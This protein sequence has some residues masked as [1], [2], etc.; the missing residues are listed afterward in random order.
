MTT[1]VTS[2]PFHFYAPTSPRQA[3]T[4]PLTTFPTIPDGYETVRASLSLEASQPRY[5]RYAALDP[6]P[7]PLPILDQ[8][9]W[10]NDVGFV[11]AFLAATMVVTAREAW[12]WQR[13]GG[14][15]IFSKQNESA[16]V[17]EQVECIARG[18]INSETDRFILDVEKQAKSAQTPSLL[19]WWTRPHD[20][21]N[22]FTSEHVSQLLQRAQRENDLSQPA[23]RLLHTLL[24]ARPDLRVQISR[25]VSQMAQTKLSAV[26]FLF[27]VARESRDP[28]LANEASD[29]AVTALLLRGEA[30]VLLFK[31][32]LDLYP[33][34]L[35][36]AP[37]H[38]ICQRAQKGEAAL[39][40]N[41][42]HILSWAA[43]FRP[44]VF[45]SSDIQALALAAQTA[46]RK[47]Q[48][49]TL[50]TLAQILF[51]L[52]QGHAD[53]FKSHH[54]PVLGNLQ[55]AILEIPFLFEIAH[56]TTDQTF[57]RVMIVARWGVRQVYPLAELVG[58]LRHKPQDVFDK[59]LLAAVALY[60]RYPHHVDQ[61]AYEQLS[62]QAALAA[63]TAAVLALAQAF[64]QYASR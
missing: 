30:E 61:A 55:M 10:Q 29:Q 25:A 37:I 52:A 44:D 23:Y 2:L 48:I 36:R 18:E 13:E 19:H 14:L 41:E 4:L 51:D 39:S 15:R 53:V 35:Q 26:C 27:V 33:A 49:Q 56:Q 58:Y 60:K 9:G 21:L 62:L 47:E 46:R 3:T 32:Y 40:Q 7:M 42:L 5:E 6:S 17:T 54:I 22:L 50:Q 34:S 43:Q 57:A 8:S 1:P 28:E 64:P 20:F 11:G 63:N 24:Q 16:R 38:R 31:D 12:L 59:A 45:V